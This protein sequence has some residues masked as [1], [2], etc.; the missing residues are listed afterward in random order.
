MIKISMTESAPKQTRITTPTYFWH[1]SL[2]E[3]HSTFVTKQ[4]THD[5][6][7][8]RLLRIMDTCFDRVEGCCDGYR[9]NSARYRG[10][11]VLCPRRLAIVRYAEDIILCNRT[12]TEQLRR[13][14][15][16]AKKERQQ[17]WGETTY[18]EGGWSFASERPAPA[19]IQRQALHEEINKGHFANTCQAA[20]GRLHHHLSLPLARRVCEARLVVPREYVIDPRLATKLVDPL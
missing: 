3:C 13:P 7:A 6:H 1:E 5:R 8:A 11:K 15:S 10:N 12:G 14:H 19:P 2:K 16:S 18:R 20:C 4:V 9:R 17:V